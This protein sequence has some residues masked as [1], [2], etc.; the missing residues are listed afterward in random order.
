VGNQDCFGCAPHQ[1]FLV[2]VM[3]R[4]HLLS[5]GFTSPNGAAFLFPLLKFHESLRQSGMMLKLFFR[6][7]DDLT[8]CDVLLVDSKFHK[9][10]WSRNREQVLEQ[11]GQWAEQARVIYCDTTDSSGSLQSELLPIVDKY[12]KSQLLHD[13]QAY[14]RPLYGNRFFADYYHKSKGVFDSSPEWSTPVRDKEGLNKLVLSWNT[15]LADYSLWG[16]DLMKVY[17][18]LPIKS[19]LRFSKPLYVADKHRPLDVSCR[20]GITYHR[21]T[22]AWQRQQIRELMRNQLRTDKLNRRQY[23]KELM[24]SKVVVSPFGW[25]EITL[26]DFE[27]FITGGLLLKPTLDYMDTWPNLFIAEETMATFDW[28][29]QNFLAVLDEVLRDVPR[30]THIAREGQRRYAKYTSGSEAAHL[31]VNHFK[32]M[33][34]F[35]ENR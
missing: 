33:I 16:P 10:Q 23:F 7:E 30:R 1:E 9:F 14:C 5:P 15:G 26:K 4:I 12:A 17:R 8:D 24:S 2:S 35:N 18:R 3:I 22:V 27:V 21:E 29:L 28:D 6:I 34:A 11:F 31:F 32:N 19:L 20:F 25:G 13:K